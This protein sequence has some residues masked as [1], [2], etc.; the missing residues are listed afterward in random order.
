MSR[1]FI[2]KV[3][4]NSNGLSKSELK[5]SFD[6]AIAEIL[7]LKDLKLFKQLITAFAKAEGWKLNGNKSEKT[8]GVAGDK[9]AL[10]RY[11]IITDGETTR[12][13]DNDDS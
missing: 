1:K 5:L 8:D 11:D 4:N 3:I 12:Q 13:V 10:Q 9:S 2:D 7:K 6:Y